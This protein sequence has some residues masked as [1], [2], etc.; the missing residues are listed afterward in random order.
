MFLSCRIIK[1]RCGIGSSSLFGLYHL[2]T[3]ERLSRAELGDILAVSLG[4]DPSLIQRVLR[5]EIHGP[6]YR[7][8][9]VSLNCNKFLKATGFLATSIR[10]VFSGEYRKKGRII[11]IPTNHYTSESGC[12]TGP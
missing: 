3:E 4:Y 9:D 5:S 11:L 8:E 2:V 10:E 12:E 6:V 1:G 7:A